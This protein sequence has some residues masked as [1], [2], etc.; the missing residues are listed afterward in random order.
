M[1]EPVF[2]TLKEHRGL[3]RFYRRGLAGVNAEFLLMALAFNLTRLHA[4]QR[5]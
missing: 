2:G 3:R 5:R 4:L 1:I